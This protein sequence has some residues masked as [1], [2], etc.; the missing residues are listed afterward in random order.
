M[1]KPSVLKI[2][3]K[4]LSNKSQKLLVHQPLEFWKQTPQ[5]KTKEILTDV[6]NNRNYHGH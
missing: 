5:W 6:D 2:L 3:S 4:Q 1:L